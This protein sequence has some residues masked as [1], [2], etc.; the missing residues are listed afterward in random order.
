MRLRRLAALFAS[1]AFGLACAELTLRAVGYSAPL[2]YQPD[3]ERGWML[4]P[5]K[6]G[7]FTQE[8]KAFVSINSA[9]L[10]DREHTVRKPPGVYRIAIVGDSYSEA[11]Q[12]P[13][14]SFVC[15]SPIVWPSS[16]HAMYLLLLS[17]GK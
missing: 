5:S 13:L 6:S 16:W 17:V 10:R 7:W 1:A 11:M 4:R 9:G 2:W 3:A 14:D 12:V 8:G 15:R